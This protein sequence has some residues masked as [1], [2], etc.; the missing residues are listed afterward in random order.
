MSQNRNSENHEHLE[1]SA[2][3]EFVADVRRLAD[4]SRARRVQVTQ[5]EFAGGRGTVEKPLGE[6]PHCSEVGVQLD[7]EPG[8][9]GLFPP[10]A[11]EIEAED[12]TETLPDPSGGRTR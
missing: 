2:W 11:I 9:Y 12:V 3:R 7:G 6:F 8:P 1:S 10:E 5:G 4:L